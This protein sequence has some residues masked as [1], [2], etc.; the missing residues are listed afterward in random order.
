M[1]PFGNDEE[2]VTAGA[3]WEKEN[4]VKAEII[5]QPRASFVEPFRPR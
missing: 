1:A 2:D 4:V 5:G 3:A